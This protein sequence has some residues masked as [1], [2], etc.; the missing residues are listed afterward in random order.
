MTF[1]A[2]EYFFL[3]PALAAAAWRWRGLQLR[4]PLRAAALVVLV[5][6]LVDPRL[7]RAS[8]G[9]DLWVLA[10]RSDSAAA[11]MALQSREIETILERAR[12]RDDRLIYVDFAGEVTRRD[13]GDPVFAGATYQTRI[14]TALEFAL[15]EMPAGRA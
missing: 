14:G 15:G 10:D 12:G 13:R 1:G 2:P 4:E 6:A 9:L 7:Q 3:L 5:L 11:A 8:G